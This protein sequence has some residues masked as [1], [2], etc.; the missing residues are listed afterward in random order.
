MSK[1]RMFVYSLTFILGYGIS[2]LII[3]LNLYTDGWNNA[4]RFFAVYLM[5]IAFGGLFV[6]IVDGVSNNIH[7]YKKRD[8]E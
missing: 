7:T 6:S 3:S 5:S 4:V 8:G 1:K 2:Y